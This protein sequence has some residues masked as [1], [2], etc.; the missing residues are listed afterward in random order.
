MTI[1]VDRDTTV[2]HEQD[3][4]AG[5]N[6]VTRPDLP[7]PADPRR[8][9]LVGGVVAVGAAAIAAIG[10]TDSGVPIC[11]SQGVFGVDC[12]LCGGLR[13]VSS[14]ARGDLVAAAD[15]NV[16]LA[17]V[18][19]AVVVVW[20]LWMVAAVRGCRL[21]RP[22]PPRWLIG[23]GLLLLVVFT[24]ARNLDAGPITDWLAATRG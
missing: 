5:G 11:W 24:V 23:S 12:P 18:L 6:P 1:E 3:R 21:R 13:C 7:D 4:D 17:V 19:P 20:A 22:S 8:G 9:A 10:P 14:L 2:E 16:V 15:H